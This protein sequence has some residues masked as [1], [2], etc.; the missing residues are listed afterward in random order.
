MFFKIKNINLCIIPNQ[1]FI[2]KYFF[3]FKIPNNT[4]GVN[5]INHP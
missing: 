3:L 1:L 4:E 2:K 5:S